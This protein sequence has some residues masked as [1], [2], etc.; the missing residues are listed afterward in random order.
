MLGPGPRLEVGALVVP[1]PSPRLFQADLLP[2][3]AEPPP[4]PLPLLR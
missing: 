4:T 2:A 3:A 1:T